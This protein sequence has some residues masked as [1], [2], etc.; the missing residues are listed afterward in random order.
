MNS[1]IRICKSNVLS[2]SNREKE[3]GRSVDVSNCDVYN[4]D[5]VFVIWRW[6]WVEDRDSSIDPEQCSKSDTCISANGMSDG[7]NDGETDTGPSITHSVVFKCIGTHKEA[8][9]QELLS[10]VAKR[11]R[12]GGT[13]PV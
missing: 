6:V 7:S 10:L 12:E 8:H 3:F 4:G 2:I 11:M 9:Y 1:V 13:V 5:K